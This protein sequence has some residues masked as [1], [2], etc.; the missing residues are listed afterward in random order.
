MEDPIGITKGAKYGNIHS[1]DSKYDK[2]KIYQSNSDK[3]RMYRVKYHDDDSYFECISLVQIFGL[4]VYLFE[5]LGFI[6]LGIG[7]NVLII[8]GL[9]FMAS[10]L[11]GPIVAEIAKYVSKKYKN[12]CKI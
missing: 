11:L 7:E 4:L 10:L 9:W 1:R 6:Y 2:M 8:A 5:S 3:S 12:R